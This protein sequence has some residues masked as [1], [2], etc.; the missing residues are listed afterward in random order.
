MFLPRHDGVSQTYDILN[1]ECKRRDHATWKISYLHIETK[2]HLLTLQNKSNYFWTRVYI[3]SYFQDCF[4]KY[5][6]IC[7]Q[8]QRSNPEGMWVDRCLTTTKHTKSRNMYI[9]LGMYTAQTLCNVVPRPA[10]IAERCHSWNCMMTS[11]NVNTFYITG[12]LWVESTGH[13]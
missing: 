11:Q 12:H 13:Q 4:T 8:C 6:M 7:P 5:L 1:D 10:V 2:Y 9:F 3:Y